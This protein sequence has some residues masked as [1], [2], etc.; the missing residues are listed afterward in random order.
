MTVMVPIHSVSPSGSTAPLWLTPRSLYAHVP[1]C[2]ARCGYCDFAIAVGR[3]EAIDTYL[4]ALEAELARVVP[5]SPLPMDTWFVGGG[6]PSVLSAGQLTRLGRILARAGPLTA[7]AEASLEANPESFDAGKAHALASVGFTR[8]SLGVQSFAGPTLQA[9]ERPHDAALVESAVAAARMA[10]LEVSLD[11]IFGAPGQTLELWRE[12]LR[13]AVDLGP[14]HLSVYGLTYERGTPLEKKARARLVLP[15]AEEVER[16]LYD[17]AMTHLEESGYRQ[18]EISNFSRPGHASRHNRAYWANH[19]H[20]GLGM[21]AAGYRDGSRTLNT[22]DLD[23]YLR[24]ALAG[25]NTAFQTESLTP[26]ETAHETLMLNL[27]RLEGVV[28]EEFHGRT[29]FTLASVLGDAAAP[30]V[31]QGLLQAD[32]QGLR[33]TRAGR[34]VADAVIVK[35]LAG[36]PDHPAEPAL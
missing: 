30:L 21:G 13:R 35:L 23:R 31:E 12:D 19:A 22:R 10:G 29:G 14:E 1:F 18:Y 36:A 15:L 32:A 17:L 6:T 7:G 2:A 33:L 3:E 34:F 11:L 25:E 20:L 9:L 16:D 8:V 27:R 28:A 5:G 4:G 24:Q 26:C